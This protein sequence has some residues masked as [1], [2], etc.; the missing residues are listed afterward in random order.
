MKN[1]EILNIQN[2]IKNNSKEFQSYYQ[3]TLSDLKKNKK[4]NAYLDLVENYKYANDN[5]SS[6][7]NK[8]LYAVKDN[9][10]V[11]DTITTGGSLFFENYKSTYTATV[12]KLLDKAGAIPICKANLDEFGLGGTG[13]FSAYGDV[14]NPLDET[15]IAGGSSSGSAVL[16]AKKI[17]SFA[18]GTDTGDS[19]RMPASFLGVYGYKPTYGLVS[20][21][22]V[23][24][25]SPSIDHV[26][27]F[28]NSVED[29]AIVMDVINQHDSND[30]TSQDIKLDFLKD[31]DKVDN[32]VKVATLTNVVNLLNTKEKKLFISTLQ[33]ISKEFQIYESSLPIELIHLIPVVYEILSYSE[34]VSCYQN[35]IGISFGKKG[36]GKTFEEKIID[37]R[38]KNFGKELKKRFVLGSFTTLKENEKLL[39]KCKKIRRLIVDKAEELL[40]KYDFI[41]MPGASSIAPKVSD[42]KQ[43]KTKPSDVDNYLQIANF[44]GFPSLT[45]PMGKID[46]IPIGINIMGRINSDNKLL[47]FAKKI[48]SLI[49]EQ[50]EK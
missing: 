21:F 40:K 31:F 33:K 28:A 13:L 22:G 14:I 2:R 7:L 47:A 3:N 17:V 42:V 16:V 5:P 10:N 45:I 12:V 20:R 27:V 30:F 38:T 15:R 41:I 48:D 23:F 18:L 49:G 46:N 6:K 35:I 34:A 44:G 9:I 26:G 11:K 37:T 19:I 36:Q 24:P 39:L 1:S 29:I 25:Y 43:N 4:L 32:K 50:N 8:I